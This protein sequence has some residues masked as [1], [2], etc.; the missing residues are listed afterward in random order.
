[1]LARGFPSWGLHRP[2][3][4][5]PQQPAVMC[6]HN[7]DSV[8]AAA[9]A[10]EAE[11]AAALA[12][13]QTL[14]M[15]GHIAQASGASGLQSHL[16][17]QK[18]SDVPNTGG[19]RRY[20]PEATSEL[21]PPQHKRKRSVERDSSAR[22]QSRSPDKQ[23][24]R[25]PTQHK[26]RQFT[27]DAEGSDG[28]RLDSKQPTIPAIQ[29]QN[30]LEMKPNGTNCRQSMNAT[31]QKGP[32]KP[33][34]YLGS[35]FCGVN[36]IQHS[37]ESSLR[38]RAGTWDPVIK[39]TVYIGSYDEEEEAAAAVDAWHVS[40]GRNPVN[41]RRQ[42]AAVA[43]AARRSSPLQ[44]NVQRQSGYG[45]DVS[46]DEE[47]MLPERSPETRHCKEAFN[48]DANRCKVSYPCH[49]GFVKPHHTARRYVGYG[50]R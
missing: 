42:G 41:F 25:V 39:K 49:P 1:M 2:R 20:R 28:T 47:A 44:A 3:T 12:A 27:E 29:W 21:P 15:S 45:S 6:A 10:A 31:A 37:A 33:H 32:Y 17:A 35:C 23:L 40:Q 50:P 7:V 16:E 36:G 26:A 38:W 13:A 24:G 22:K 19:R 43:P 8:A 5:R 9:A 14:V 30:A 46:Q 11:T 4:K 18:Q 48:L 34:E